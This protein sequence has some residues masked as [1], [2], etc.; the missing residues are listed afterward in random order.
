MALNPNELWQSAAGEGGGLRFFPEVNQPKEF[1]QG[2]LVLAKGTA[3]TYNTSTGKWQVFDAD[4]M[5]GTNLVKGFVWPDDI[6]LDA[7]EEV[8]GQVMLTGR[9]HIADIP[10][11]S[12][13]YNLAELSANLQANARGI[14]IIVEGLAQVR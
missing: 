1:A 14:G 2:L 13:Q 8:L 7:D 6:T 10:L 4:G 3:V 5:N 9:V 11:V 12:G